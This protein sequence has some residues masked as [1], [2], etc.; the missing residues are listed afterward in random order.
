MEAVEAVVV[1]AVAGLEEAV[2][3][4]RLATKHRFF[5][6]S[7]ADLATGSRSSSSS[8]SSSSNGRTSSSSN[9]GGRTI[10]GTGVKP[11]FG[12]GRYYGGGSVVPFT[13]GSRSPRGLAP[14]LLPLTA[15]AIFPGIWLFGAYYYAYENPYTFLNRTA[16][17]VTFPD[18]VNV[19][20]PVG[21]LC[22]Q[23]GVCG[24][25]DNGED[26]FIQELIGDGSIAGLNDSLV[27]ISDFENRRTLLINGTLPNGTTAAG[28]DE[29]SSSGIRLAALEQSG[30]WAL[31]A[32][33]V[34][35]VQYL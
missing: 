32:A 30:L 35:M 17:N 19:T 11:R 31:G 25:D 27:T 7:V 22:Q 9:L 15:L 24:C 4:V 12:G 16:A 3:Q 26:D 28:G 29:P 20:L 33:V 21:C 2:L 34:L 1:G 5:T 18:G 8:G 13:S 10:S 23:F 14:R 6:A